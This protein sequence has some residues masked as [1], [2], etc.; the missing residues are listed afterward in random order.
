[1]YVAGLSTSLPPDA[2]AAILRTIPGLEH[3]VALQWGY[4][5]EYDWV[6]P[7]QLDHDLGVRGVAGLYCAGQIAGTSGY[8]EAAAQGLVAGFAAAGRPLRPRRDEGYI[9]VLVDDLVTR[10]VGDE[11]YRMFPS[12]A[13]H[14]LLLR[15]DNADRRLTPRGR[16]LGL[17]DDASWARFEA[18]L[19]AIE[20]LRARWDGVLLRPNSP[21]SAALGE[22]GQPE[23][24]QARTVL[25]YL[26]RPDV[27]AAAVA[28]VLGDTEAPDVVEQ[29]EIDTRYEGYVARAEH[30][31]ADAARLEGASLDPLDL[32]TVPVSSEV[33]ERLLRHRP[34]TLGA[35]SRLP[36]VTPAAM[37]TLAAALVIAGA[38]R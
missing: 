22:R 10:G 5:V 36:G 21:E 19:E 18:K 2:Q 9:G 28:G 15:E 24:S 16:A 37:D 3:A 23:L 14:R 27:D 35:A 4:A 34:A 17:V 38:R 26:R 13:E 29:V 33:R 31:R 12:R 8:E 6:D 11:P 30:R 25:A 20:R 7:T 1:V 32:A